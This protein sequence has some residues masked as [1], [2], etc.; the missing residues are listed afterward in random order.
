MI[1]YLVSWNKITLF[2]NLAFTKFLS[3]WWGD[4]KSIQTLFLSMC[5]CWTSW[6]K[7]WCFITWLACFWN[8]LL[9][10][11]LQFLYHYKHIDKPC[12]RLPKASTLPRC[13]NCQRHTFHH[14]RKCSCKGE[15]IFTF[16]FDICN[17]FVQQFVW[18]Q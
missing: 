6:S 11:Q 3:F 4:L 18:R 2:A 13:F 15:Q 7:W 12:W 1:L 9:K 10:N 17:Y 16:I 8:W 14:K 5:P